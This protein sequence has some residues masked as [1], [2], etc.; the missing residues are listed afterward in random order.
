MKYL[1]FRGAIMTILSISKRL[2]QRGIGLL[3]LMLSVSIIAVL[4]IMATRYYSTVKRSNLI[5]Q[6]VS[7]IGMIVTAATQWAQPTP[8]TGFEGMTFALLRQEKLLSSHM[9]SDT[10]NSPFG[11]PITLDAITTSSFQ[12]NF[13]TGVGECKQLKNILKK[14]QNYINNSEC[15]S[16]L[17]KINYVIN[18]LDTV[19]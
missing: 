13:E 19:P 4:I 3:E 15:D 5:N 6:T 2:H 9:D 14:E 16:G 17:V 1:D 18:V 7:D 8:N 11:T 12:I 10:P